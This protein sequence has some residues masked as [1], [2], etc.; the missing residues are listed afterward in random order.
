MNEYERAA[1]TVDLSCGAAPPAFAPVDSGPKVLTKRGRLIVSSAR[2]WRDEDELL[3]G[4]I[5]RDRLLRKTVLE[6]AA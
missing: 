1:L 6:M 2:P 5:E 3:A 4:L